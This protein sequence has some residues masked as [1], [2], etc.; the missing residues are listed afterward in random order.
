MMK[1][2]KDTVVV[3]AVAVDAEEAAAVVAAAIQEVVMVAQA[4][5]VPV[6]HIGQTNMAA[7]K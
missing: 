2:P 7:E 3:K 6:K 4:V 1:E 5:M